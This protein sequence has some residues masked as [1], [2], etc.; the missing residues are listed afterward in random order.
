MPKIYGL[1]SMCYLF[2]GLCSIL[3]KM[4]GGGGGGAGVKMNN[5]NK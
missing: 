1:V 3:E 2:F 5:E 4:G